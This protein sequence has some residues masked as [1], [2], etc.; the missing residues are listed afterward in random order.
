MSP[1]LLFD[2]PPQRLAFT[3]PERVLVAT[4]IEEVRGVLREV[5][6]AAAAGLWAAGYVSYEA[7]PAFDSALQVRAGHVLPL[8]WF[9]LFRGPAQMPTTK[10]EAHFSAWVPSVSREAYR[11]GIDTIREAIAA[12]ETYQLNYTLRLRGQLTGEPLAA[13]EA[14]RAAQR[15]SYCAY[16]DLGAH[17][18][19]SASPELFFERRGAQL[20]TRPMKGTQPR[21]RYEEED[22]ARAAWLQASEKNRAENVMIVDLLRNDLGRVCE[23]GSVTV[24]RLMKTETYA[25]VHQLV[26]TVRGR[27]R[28]DV[29][30]I[31]CVRACFPGGS[32][33]GAPKLRTLDII[34]ALET[35]ARGVY[36]GTIGFLACNGTADLNIVIRTA[37]MTGDQLHVG[38]GGAIVLDSDAVEEYDE[39]L[40]KATAPLRA[41]LAGALDADTAAP[42]GAQQAR[43]AGTAA[44]DDR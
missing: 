43:A 34:D 26:S 4:R 15:A 31:D 1:V 12:G 8:A 2:F 21:G 10:G 30:A 7:A 27:L 44:L 41:L 25:T 11:T 19:V 6:A 28:A 37:V 3:H 16:L 33:T 39:M 18:L 20:V 22:S 24:P 35:Q 9:G 36:S 32:M 17:R 38:A 29:D 5:E 23:V 13:Y 14:L 42:C 40:L